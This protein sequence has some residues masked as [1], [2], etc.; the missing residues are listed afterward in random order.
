MSDSRT[1]AGKW[2]DTYPVGQ[3][4]YLTE[5]DGSMTA[6]QTKSHAIQ[7]AADKPAVIK[8]T[9]R[10]IVYLLTRVQAR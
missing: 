10:G 2:N 3:P 4:V 5:D 9:G 1:E 8:V 6:T 7:I